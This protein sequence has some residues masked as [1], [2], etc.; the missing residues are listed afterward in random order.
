MA[1]PWTVKKQLTFLSVFILIVAAGMLLVFISL[2]KPTCF[3]GKQNQAEEG[4]DCGGPCQ[5]CLG[6]IRDIIVVWSKVFKLD[7]GKYEAAALI[8][9][10]NLSLALPFVKYKIK[11]YDRKNIL[12]AVR[13]GETFINPGGEYVLFETNIDAGERSPVKAFVEFD[14]N[15]KWKK[16]ER[17]IPQIVVSNKSFTPLPSPRLS[18]EISNTSIFPIEGIFAAAVVYD[19]DGN[20]VAVSSTKIKSIKGKSSYPVVFTWPTPFEKEVVS[21]RIFLRVNLTHEK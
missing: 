6:K 13:E 12:V 1:I 3:D 14:K 19:K 18:A 11:L 20:A 2:N 9:N 16:I 4:I 21:S 5:P 10:P 17:E 7:N 8:R 15:L